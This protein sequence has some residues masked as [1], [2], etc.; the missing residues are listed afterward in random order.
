MSN[1]TTSA[2]NVADPDQNGADPD[3]QLCDDMDPD[4]VL[5]CYYWPNFYSVTTYYLLEKL[6]SEPMGDKPSRISPSL[7]CSSKNYLTFM[8]SSYAS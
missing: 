1:K 7:W 8:T 4:S 2:I 6:E 3:P 5:K